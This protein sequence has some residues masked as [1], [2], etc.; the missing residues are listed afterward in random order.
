[1]PREVSTSVADF[2]PPAH[3]ESQLPTGRTSSPQLEPAWR[4][5]VRT[6]WHRYAVIGVWLVL[7]A[8]FGALSPNAFL[9]WPNFANIFGTQSVLLLL[10]MSLV[11]TLTLGEFDLSVASVSGLAA[12]MVGVLTVFHHWSLGLALLA[13][14]AASAGAGVINGWLAVR[15]NVNPIVVTLGMSTL[16]LGMAEWLANLQTVG[17]V[18]GALNTVFNTRIIDLPLAFIYSLVVAVLLWYVMRHTPLG[19]HMLFVGQN[20]DVARLS[21]VRVDRLRFRGYVVG[22]LIAG[23]S[24]VMAVGIFGGFQ[25]STSGSTLLPAFA[26]AFLGTAVIDPGRFN[27]L[28][29]VIALCFLGTGI[30]GLEIVGL[31]GWIENAF[32]G[33]ALIVAVSASTVVRERALNLVKADRQQ[34]QGGGY[35]TEKEE[36]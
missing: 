8:I 20:R 9:T 16:L 31:S 34:P 14:L 3:E 5:A 36:Q 25:S 11:V 18:G 15:H 26:A 6:G 1:M 21:G 13:A 33:A 12:T 7:I 10:T 27:A 35:P 30:N 19:R 2:D 32:Y 4:D 28:G 24:G 22:S 23:L 29:S 17:G